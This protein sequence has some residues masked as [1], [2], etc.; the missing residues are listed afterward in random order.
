L[1]LHDG[2]PVQRLNAGKIDFAQHLVHHLADIPEASLA[3]GVGGFAVAFPTPGLSQDL[4]HDG[5]FAV[6]PGIFLQ[7]SSGMF[8]AMADV[9]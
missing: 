9:F 2:A 1:T 4:L 8:K 3:F 5:G 7:V 6:Y